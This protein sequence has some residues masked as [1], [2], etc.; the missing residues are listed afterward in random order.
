MF[1]VAARLGFAAYMRCPVGKHWALVRYARESDLTEPEREA[2]KKREHLDDQDGSR[3]TS[4]FGLFTGLFSLVMA[5]VS[6]SWWLAGLSGLWSAWFGAAFIH[7]LR[8][9]RNRP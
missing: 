8:A 7:A 1:M 5:I 4:A 2:L 6:R 9:T 3:F